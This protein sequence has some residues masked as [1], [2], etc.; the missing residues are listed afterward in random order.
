MG[1][2]FPPS[3]EDDDWAC[4][5]FYSSI[6]DAWRFHVFAKLSER[7]VFLG[8]EF[9]D[10]QGSLQLVTSSHLRER[11]RMLLRAVLCGGVWNGCLLGKAKKE[12][13]PC[14]FC[15]KKMVM[16]TCSGTVLFTPF[17]MFG[18]FLNLLILCPLT[19]ASGLGVFFG[20]V[21]C[22]VSMAL[23]LL[24]LGCLFW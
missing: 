5:A 21:G 19:S 17:S 18:I 2:G 11:D 10:F 22:L 23:V 24:T 8:G 9:S 6:L 20:M 14:R 16:V 13:V 4:A 1:S 12:D 15:G 3:F 7:K